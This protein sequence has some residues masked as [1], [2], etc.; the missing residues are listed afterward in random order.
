[1]AGGTTALDG[2]GQPQPVPVEEFIEG[3]DD[4]LLELMEHNPLLAE[5]GAVIERV[6]CKS[7]DRGPDRAQSATDACHD[8][9]PP[10]SCPDAGEQHSH[11]EEL[12]EF[13][14]GL[15][16][17]R[18]PNGDFTVVKA[19][20]KRE[21]IVDLDEWVGAEPIW[22]IPMPTCM[23]DF[24]LN[25]EGEIE[26]ADFGEETADFMWD[27]SHP[28]LDQVRSSDDVIGNSN[29]DRKRERNKKMRRAVEHERKRLCV[30]QREGSPATTEAGRLLQER[31]RTVGP[32]ADHC[33][34]LAADQILRRRTG[35][36][37]KPN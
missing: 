25:D 27:H 7:V 5:A 31:L 24:R 20:T 9:K 3:T 19:D 2:Q 12:D 36:K 11:E 13:E 34:Q 15:Y 29:G 28:H 35:E 37:G 16:L 30:V 22:L 1:M 23:I 21:A 10:D 17:C 26:L 14:S 18:W 6:C 32:V 33:V 8:S 4:A